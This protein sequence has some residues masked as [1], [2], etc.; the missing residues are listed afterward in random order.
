[1]YFFNTFDR[2]LIAVRYRYVLWFLMVTF[3]SIG[4]R[5]K[6][7]LANW[8]VDAVAPLAYGS[9][10]FSDYAPEKYFTTSQDQLLN[11]VLSD[12]LLNLGLDTLIGIPDTTITESF[13]LPIQIQAVPGF[14]FYQDTKTSRYEIKDVKLTF[15]EVRESELLIKLKNTIDHP[16]LFS[17]SILNAVNPQ[18]DTFYVEE[19]VEANSALDT[20]YDMNGYLL[21]LRGLDGNE[22]NT[23]VSNFSAMIHPSVPDASVTIA[24]G[25]Q[26]TIENT[27]KN[28]IP[29]YV[30][31]YFGQHNVLFNESTAIDFLD[32]FPF[33]SLNITDFDVTMTI[34]NG[35]GVD[36]KLRMEQIGAENTASGNAASLSH[37]LI[38]S[39][40]QFTRAL[41]LYAP[42]DPVKHIRKQFK[43]NAGN[44]NLDELLEVRPDV[45][46]SNLALEVNPL[47]NVTYNND[48]V[49]YG[50]N[51]T[52]WMDLRI[53]L[54]I[55]LKGLELSDTVAFKYDASEE[56]G[57][58][59]RVNY[60][61]LRCIMD[62]GYP[63]EAG[64]QFYLQDTTGTEIDSLLT[65]MQW[66]EGAEE[67]SNGRVSTP[68]RSVIEIPVTQS[69]LD[70]LELANALRLKVI[71]N[72][73]GEDSVHIRS[74]YK[75]DYK[76]VGEFNV[77]VRK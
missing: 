76:I 14:V 35:M 68:R 21:D 47:G 66:I 34:D 55:G 24:A 63:F 22:Y 36:M 17:Y 4:C 2:H 33:Q 7:E 25:S 41:Q 74:G 38:G 46:N 43:F 37:A 8:E 53:P 64:L 71:L 40:Q 48:F 57:P 49:Y 6:L 19:R 15:A 52:A 18:G 62:N 67:E 59:D 1:M 28:V 77:N 29:E 3:V 73:V 32:E 39:D 12:T 26:F 31:G 72:T 13:A 61:T 56:G 5:K 20:V 42:D 44:S 16:V 75:M 27:V 60:G 30:Q 58:L 23:V 9:V 65:A 69:K 70:Q 54:V 10:N 45:L 50:H 51:L 11:L